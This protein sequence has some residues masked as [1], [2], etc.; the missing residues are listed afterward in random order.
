MD[1]KAWIGV[2]A[3]VISL[4]TA[5]WAYARSGGVADA[6]IE[7]GLETAKKEISELRDK[8]KTFEQLPNQIRSIESGQK[9]LEAA[10]R[11]LVESNRETAK[12][13][14]DLNRDL[15]EYFRQEALRRQK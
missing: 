14:Q 15:R 11:D 1:W 5:A 10:Q 12:S 2:S 6:R 9:N 8:V 4:C 3:T 13:V 7:I